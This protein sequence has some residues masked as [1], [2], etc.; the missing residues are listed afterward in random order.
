MQWVWAGVGFWSIAALLVLVIDTPI[1]KEAE[2]WRL[3]LATCLHIP[4]FLAAY[5][6]GFISWLIAG[7]SRSAQ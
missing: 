6:S 4:I 5:Q 3:M 7:W 1:H 2:K